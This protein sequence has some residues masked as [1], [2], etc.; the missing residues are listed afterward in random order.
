MERSTVIICQSINVPSDIMVFG[1]M[2]SFCSK[3]NKSEEDSQKYNYQLRKNGC[4]I[5]RIHGAAFIMRRV[6]F[7]INLNEA[8]VTIEKEGEEIQ[9]KC[10]TK[11]EAIYKLK[12]TSDNIY[13]LERNSVD[14]SLIAA[15]S[16]IKS[17]AD[18]KSFNSTDFLTSKI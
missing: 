17:I 6:S 8:I 2:A 10:L 18:L 5:V 14:Y 4:F 7:N 12:Y 16:E 1:S 13:H 15:E 11:Q 9:F 3:C